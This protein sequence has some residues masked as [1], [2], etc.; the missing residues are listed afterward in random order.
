MGEFMKEI[1]FKILKSVCVNWN[2]ED[3]NTKHYNKIRCTINNK[4]C[5]EDD[6]PLLK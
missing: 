1:T 3:R 5:N 6:C 4:I 2:Q